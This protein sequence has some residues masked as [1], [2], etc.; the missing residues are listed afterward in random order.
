[1]S[2][3]K[4]R[5]EGL[6]KQL[7]IAEA[8]RYKAEAGQIAE[9]LRREYEAQIMQ[10]YALRVTT[11]G[12]GGGE[13]WCKGIEVEV[14]EGGMVSLHLDQGFTHSADGRRLE[15]TEV[16]TDL[17]VRIDRGRDEECDRRE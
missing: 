9:L 15:V 5:V 12:E 11:G 17:S 7:E 2:Q 6:W 4:E 10:N 16:Y 8:L 13:L 3:T 14:E 1:M